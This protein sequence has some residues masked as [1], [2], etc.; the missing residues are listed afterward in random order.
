MTKEDAMNEYFEWL[1]DF[2]CDKQHKKYKKLLMCL[3]DTGFRYTVENDSNRF[4]DGMDLRVRFAYERDCRDAVVYL[5]EP[6]SVLE[7]LVALSLRCE[8]HIMSDPDIGDRTA[9]WFWGMISN[10]GLDAMTD[11]GFNRMFVRDRL[12]IFMDRRYRSNG[13]GGGLFTVYNARRDL[14]I[15]EIWYQM[16]WYLNEIFN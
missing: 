1:C 2:V 13:E 14:R 15:V 7:M 4:E 5:D 9:Q 6:C 8:E 3:H 16:L 11:T 10:L 12:D